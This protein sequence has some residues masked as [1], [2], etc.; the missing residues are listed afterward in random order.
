MDVSIY[1]ASQLQECLIN[2]LTY[3]SIVFSDW[4]FSV[5]VFFFWRIPPGYTFLA[6][7]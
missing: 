3:L 1:S 6:N 4:R 7:K 5:L 2:L